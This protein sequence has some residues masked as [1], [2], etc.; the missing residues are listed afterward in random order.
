M[1]SPPVSVLGLGQMAVDDTTVGSTLECDGMARGPAHRAWC[2]GDAHRVRPDPPHE[3]PR[4]W[5]M[6][7]GQGARRL[8]G[9]IRARE[10]PTTARPWYEEGPP[11]GPSP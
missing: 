6:E 1:N 11:R 9:G 10:S 2:A 7:R 8:A 4:L 3:K 5:G